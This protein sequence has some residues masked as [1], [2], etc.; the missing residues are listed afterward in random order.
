MRLN[1]LD[2]NRVMRID[3]SIHHFYQT[4][5]SGGSALKFSAVSIALVSDIRPA[6]A[7]SDAI[8]LS[9]Y[10]LYDM[11]VRFLNIFRLSQCRAAKN[12]KAI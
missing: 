4:P 2:F 7:T 5:G 1:Q 9:E 8:S 10:T 3:Q 11:N 12:S 6:A